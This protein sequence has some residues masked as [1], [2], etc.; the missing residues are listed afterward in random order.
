[1]QHQKPKISPKPE[2]GASVSHEKLAQSYAQSRRQ[3][4]PVTLQNARS[5]AGRVL[6]LLA[7]RKG[8]TALLIALILV[9]STLEITIPFLTQRLIDGIIRSVKGIDRFA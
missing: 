2:P 1:M 6:R 4:A 3:L 7:N 8:T 9:T 5:S